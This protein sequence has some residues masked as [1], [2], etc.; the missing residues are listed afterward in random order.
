MFFKKLFLK[1]IIFKKIYPTDLLLLDDGFANLKLKKK[2]NI[3][4]FEPN[5][6]YFFEFIKSLFI[7]MRLFF[8]KKFSIIYFETLINRLNPKLAIGHEMNDKLFLYKKILPSSKSICYQFAFMF[9]E[10]INSFYKKIFNNKVVDYFF[11]Y[12]SRSIS[13]IKNL[14]KTNFFINGSTKTNEKLKKISNNYQITYV[15]RFKPFTHIKDKETLKMVKSFRKFDSLLLK[16]LD[17]Y[18]SNKKIKLEIAFTSKRKDKKKYNFFE[19]E[20]KYFN[21][22]IKN[23]KISE[24][25]F[26]SCLKSKL[27]IS[28]TSNLGYELLFA[29]KKVLFLDEIRKKQYS[30]FTKKKGP[31][32]YYGKNKKKIKNNIDK[33][34][35]IDQINWLKKL[36]SVNK[37]FKKFHA[38]INLYKKNNFFKKKVY[39][40]LKEND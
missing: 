11:A 14:L 30:F 1:R 19:E 3:H 18:C 8:K 6:Y 28:S 9:K 15:S 25:N 20:L 5:N 10:D 13:I 27:I 32:W 35:N 4:Y 31:F 36:Y 40:I 12:D 29:K 2:F 22:L 33:V 24:D 26:H 34:F 21:S 7:F 16:I 39:E 38:N 37:D 17:R 23:F